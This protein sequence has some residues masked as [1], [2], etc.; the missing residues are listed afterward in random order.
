MAAE[1]EED[2]ATPVVEDGSNLQEKM[3]MERKNEYV[4]GRWLERL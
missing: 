1:A 2:A 4:A 3:K